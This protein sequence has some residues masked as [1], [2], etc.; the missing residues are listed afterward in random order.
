MTEDSIK[1]SVVQYLKSY[2]KYRPRFQHDEALAPTLA[3][4]DMM[5]SNGIFADG[6]LSFLDEKGNQFVAT[7]EASSSDSAFE[8][9]YRL[10]KNLLFWDAIAVSALVVS[11]AFSYI[12]AF[13]NHLIASRNGGWIFFFT[14]L[15]FLIIN[16][17]YRFSFKKMERYRSIFAI[18]QFKQYF[19]DEQWVAIGNDT[20]KPEE[21]YFLQE[22]KK[23]CVYNGFGLLSMDDEFHVQLL[24]T[25]AREAV[26][27][28]KRQRVPFFSSLMESNYTQK[29]VSW[30][31][32]AGQLLMR[33]LT[34]SSLL[35]FHRPYY[36]QWTITGFSSLIFVVAMFRYINDTPTIFADEENPQKEIQKDAFPI[37]EKT[38]VDDSL[39]IWAFNRKKEMAI[40]EE[41]MPAVTPDEMTTKGNE[42]AED[43]VYLTSENGETIFYD[44]E[45]LNLEGDNYVIMESKQ[46][47]LQAAKQKIAQLK[48]KGVEANC[49]WLG[50]FSKSDLSYVVFF[51]LIYND[52]KEAIQKSKEF[53]KLLKMKGLDAS[54]IKIVSLV[55]R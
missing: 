48:A 55:N 23:Q 10:E 5:T 13:Q 43:G 19:A 39:H 6:H 44:C 3:Q 30:T 41:P 1:K 54:K 49:V 33:P 47:D 34:E 4:T 15:I 42:A 50:C 38:D 46:A 11:F 18:E 26:Y 53:Y 22:L 35:R 36:Y 51:D 37:A 25:P 28:K 8:V 27:G 2:Y 24:I 45:R 21:D 29:A 32:D 52:K 20:F 14:I 31:Q 16:I 12:F 40:I 9:K 17:I 7:F